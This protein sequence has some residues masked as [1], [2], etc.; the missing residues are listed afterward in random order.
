ML[1]QAPQE[2][3]LPRTR[4]TL[5]TLLSVLTGLAVRTPAGLWGVLRRLGLRWRRGREF[6]NSPDPERADKLG[7]IEAILTRARTLP[8]QVVALWLDELT[9]YRLPTVAFTW[10]DGLK[11]PTKTRMTPGNNTKGRV[12]AALNPLTGQLLHRL[13]AKIGV[14]ELCQFYVYLRTLFPTAELYVIQDNWPVHFLPAVLHTAIAL[15]IVLVRLP[16]YSSWLNPIEKL[17]HWLKRDVIHMHPWADDWPRLKAE[18]TRF[19]DRFAH[20]NTALLRYVGLL[21]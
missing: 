8:H 18:V 20:P 21:D 9:F 6:W 11:R 14:T 19:L 7:W 16:T 2:H 3:G 5:A 17:W 13:R 15:D 12:V 4:W 1:H 10:D